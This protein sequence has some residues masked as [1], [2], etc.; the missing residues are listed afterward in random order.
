MSQF[1]NENR[2]LDCRHCYKKNPSF[3]LLS[4]EELAFLDEHRIE[5]RFK[6]GEVVFKQGTPLTHLVILNEGLGKIYVEGPNGRDLILNFAMPFEIIGGP[7]MHVDMRHHSSLMVLE[8][9]R[10]CFLEMAAFKQVMK[11]NPDFHEAFVADCSRRFLHVLNHFVVLTQKNMEGRIA[12]ALLYLK[13][14]VFGQGK[15]RLISRQDLADLTAMTKESAMRVLKD[16]KSEGLI[17]EN[18]NDIDVLDEK[19]LARI[20]QL[21]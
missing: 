9:S 6:E 4:E 10:A 12:E 21:S 17:E 18:A 7:G 14:Q 3:S 16:F 11:S 1:L 15:I 19:A 5:V 20:A 8:K 13:N 2:C